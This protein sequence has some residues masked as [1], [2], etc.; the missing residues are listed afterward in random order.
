MADRFQPELGQF[1]KQNDC[2]YYELTMEQHVQG[3]IC[4]IGEAIQAK[5]LCDGNNPA[6]NSGAEFVNEVFALRSYCWCD[7]DR[8]MDGCPPNF[9]CGDFAASWYKHLLRGA[10]QSREISFDEMEAIR[11]KCIDSL[12]SPTP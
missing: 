7:G 6:G 1:L 10:S 12:P 2:H 11:R 8:H 4:A 5:G 9:E 3:A